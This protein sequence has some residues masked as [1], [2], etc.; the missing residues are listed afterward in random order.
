MKEDNRGQ[1]PALWKRWLVGV[2]PFAY[3]ASVLAVLLGA[4]IAR[5]SG[6]P[7][8]W[9]LLGL[10]LLGI[11]CFHTG[12][13]LLNDCFDHRR[14]LDARV[15]PT[16]GAIVR[17]WLTERQVFRGGVFTLAVGALCGL[18]LAWRVGWPVLLM[19]AIGTLCAAGYTT[20]RFCFKYRGGGDLAIFISFGLLTIFG[21]F[22]VQ[23]GRFSWLPV[24]WSLPLS[25][26]T[27]AILHANNWRDIETDP[28]KGCVTVAGLLGPERSGIYYRLLVLLPFGLVALITLLGLR[29]GWP[30][31][32]PP[33]LL[34]VFLTFPA[35]LR[36]ARTQPHEVRESSCMLDGRTAQAHLAFGILCT[37][38]FWIS[39]P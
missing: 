18:I 35:V 27:V 26:F 8:R 6:C 17:G 24:I 23:A 1:M 38:A 22:Y 39:R 25:L 36:L 30:V 20:P 5:Y 21:S 2:R 29:P 10:T 28:L 16:S 12:A 19:G 15:L 14:G 11:V 7:T 4:A 3:T 9:G 34:G 37:L 13:N 32:A 31:P 33:A